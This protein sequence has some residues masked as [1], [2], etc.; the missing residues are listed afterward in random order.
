[1]Q[2]NLFFF[3]FTMNRRRVRDFFV[4]HT[5]VIGKVGIQFC[6]IYFCDSN[7]NVWLIMNLFFICLLLRLHILRLKLFIKRTELPDT[8]IY[9][10]VNIKK[11][12]KKSSLDFSAMT[13]SFGYHLKIVGPNTLDITMV[14]WG[15]RWKIR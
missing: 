8:G 15:L 4:V 12:P 9:N 14:T 7:K 5:L 10:S 3:C 13:R 6:G 11:R 1:M 2:Q